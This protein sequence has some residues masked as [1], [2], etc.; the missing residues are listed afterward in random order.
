[1]SW[2]TSEV[3]ERSFIDGAGVGGRGDERE[4]GIV[5]VDGGGKTRRGWTGLG[6]STSRIGRQIER[7]L[8]ERGD[9]VEVGSVEEVGARGDGELE[10]RAEGESGFVHAFSLEKTMVNSLEI[11]R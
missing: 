1:M 7:C 5:V 4:S 3:D 8:R 9:D 2:S 10:G 6:G 11:V